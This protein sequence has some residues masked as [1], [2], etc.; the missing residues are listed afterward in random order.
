MVIRTEKEIDFYDLMRG[1]WGGAVDTLE[2]IE[3]EGKEDEFMRL[4]EQE[5]SNGAGGTELNDFITFEDDYIFEALGMDV[6]E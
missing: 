2:R 6:Y 4:L 1:S 3:E 5:Y